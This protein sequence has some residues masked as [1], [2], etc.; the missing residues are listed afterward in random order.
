MRDGLVKAALEG[1]KTA[2]SSLLAEWEHEREALPSVGE[3][4]T[5][6][7]SDARPV[8]IIELRAVEIIRLG[9]ADH[10]LALEEGEG[11]GSVGEWREAHER[12]WKTEVAPLLPDS[13]DAPLNDDTL[14]VVERFRLVE[15]A[16]AS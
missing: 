10:Q 7:D 2:T 3:R 13:S 6:V 15:R 9:D 5:V 11:F 12:F 4:Q 8:A 1:H 14:I 16:R